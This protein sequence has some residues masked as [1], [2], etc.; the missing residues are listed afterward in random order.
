MR[1]NS[2]NLIKQNTIASTRQTDTPNSTSPD[3]LPVVPVI[4]RPQLLLLD[5]KYSKIYIFWNL[6][7]ILYN[8]LVLQILWFCQLVPRFQHKGYSGT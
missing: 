6:H 7:E 8:Y 4:K 3:D 2:A 5:S 1:H